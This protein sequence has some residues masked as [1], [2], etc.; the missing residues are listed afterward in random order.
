MSK[1]G[2]TEKGSAAGGGRRPS[3]TGGVVREAG[4]V[5]WERSSAE[6]R[7][8][9]NFRLSQAKIDRA[10]EVLG[11]RT[12]TETIEAALDLAT[13]GARLAEGIQAMKGFRWRALPEAEE[14]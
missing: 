7:T 8:R 1:K 13:F 5:E 2:D 11:T 4:A 12:D 14:A 10:K 9:K 3:R 6:P